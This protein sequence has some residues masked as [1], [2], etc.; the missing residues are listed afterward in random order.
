LEL[1]PLDV[2]PFGQL[3]QQ[4]AVGAGEAVDRLIRFSHGKEPYAARLHRTSP[5]I[6]G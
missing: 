3:L 2:I 4:R 5:T 6:G 1:K